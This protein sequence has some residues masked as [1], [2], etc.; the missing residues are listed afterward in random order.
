[1]GL[2]CKQVKCGTVDSCQM[3]TL[4]KPDCIYFDFEILD[5]SNHE[6]SKI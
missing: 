6:P 3:G 4:L 1:M 5:G 2:F